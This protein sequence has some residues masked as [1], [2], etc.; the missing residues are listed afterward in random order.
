MQTESSAS[1]R[2][3]G[4]AADAADE[5]ERGRAYK[6]SSTRGEPGDRGG[7]GQVKRNM[8]LPLMRLSSQ[9][10]AITLEL[11]KRHG[12]EPFRFP[13][14]TK[15]YSDYL[16]RIHNPICLQEIKNKIG[17]CIDRRCCYYFGGLQ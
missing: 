13:V 8:R 5:S 15:K 11:W 3:R 1:D 7:L 9:L 6:G 14:D 17:Q 2:R 4:Q 10:E 16:I 12:A